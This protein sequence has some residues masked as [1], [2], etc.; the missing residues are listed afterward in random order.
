MRICQSWLEFKAR[1]LNIMGEAFTIG[2]CNLLK[3]SLFSGGPAS[4]N[5]C[6][7]ARIQRF[8]SCLLR[9][10]LVMLFPLLVGTY[11]IKL[12]NDAYSSSKFN[13]GF[14]SPS[15]T[16]YLLLLGGIH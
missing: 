13:L 11:C 7:C 15:V 3:L 2:T 9:S 10:P 1:A 4:K 8:T 6:F 14:V 5:T 12:V 16:I